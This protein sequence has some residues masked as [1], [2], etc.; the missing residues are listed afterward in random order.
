MKPCLKKLSLLLALAA[1]L[2][3]SFIDAQP[4][5]AQTQSSICIQPDGSI[6]GTD[7]I[8]KDE[9]VYTL[10]GDLSGS[11]KNG[12]CFISIR[13]DGIMLDGLG[14]TILGTRTGVAIELKGRSNVVIKNLFINNFGVG[15]DLGSDYNLET[16][17]TTNST[18]NQILNN[19]ITTVYDGIALQ[20]ARNN[21]I[22]GNTITSPSSSF[23]IDVKVSYGNTIADNHLFGGGI[24]LYKQ[25]Q[26]TFRGNTVDGKPI[27]ILEGASN[28][29]VDG[30][31]QVLLY[32][33]TD[34]T[35]KNVSPSTDLK[36]AITLYGTNNSQIVNCKGNIILENSNHNTISKNQLTSTIKLYLSHNNQIT[37]NTINSKGDFGINLEFCLNNNIQANT[38][39]TIGKVGISFASSNGNYIHGNLIYGC[40]SGIELTYTHFT[41]T[42]PPEWASTS[43]N[44]SI[45]ANNVTGCA[46]GISLN[47][48]SG[49]MVFA[50]NI[51]G[52][53]ELGVRISIANGNAFYH[54][55]FINNKQDVYE[56]HSYFDRPNGRYISYYSANNTWDD[57]YPSGGNYWSNYNGT[58]ADGD[59]IGDTPYIAF[60]NQTDNYPL[61]KP[62]AIQ[63]SDVT[64]HPFE[65]PS[66]EE[67]EQLI[68][69]SGEPFPTTLVIAPIASATV[70]GVGVFVY[71]KKYKH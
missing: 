6:E 20:A 18:N 45:F 23:G 56:E 33:C 52:C 7:K 42:R 9:Q 44:N 32:G 28:Q 14:H 12:E 36:V 69:Q 5:M 53:G 24:G 47:G 26:N 25:T 64:P 30:A 71:F 55:N 66:N 2:T 8:V 39:S 68:E 21:S 16:Q 70:V 67:Q 27:V 65:E 19:H 49:N 41:S 40:E 51:V 59:G 61:M 62:F 60:E 22:V 15:I 48:V 13:K 11:A 3:L 43:I 58:D 17:I 34:M 10:V 4:A 29:V 35:V 54:N 1:V 63:D 37:E 57:G 46:I 31:A 50:N 38:I